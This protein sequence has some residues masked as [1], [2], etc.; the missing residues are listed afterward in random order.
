MRNIASS[1]LFFLVDLHSVDMNYC[2]QHYTSASFT[3]FR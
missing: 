2:S 3:A 1:F